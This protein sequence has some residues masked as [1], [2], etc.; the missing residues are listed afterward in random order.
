LNP[1]K[2]VGTKSRTPRRATIFRPSLTK[3]LLNGI[4]KNSTVNAP[5]HPL[6]DPEESKFEF[7]DLA[8]IHRVVRYLAQEQRQLKRKSDHQHTKR[9]VKFHLA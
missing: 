3:T 6:F 7:E 9:L 2:F 5:L 8:K 4:H 1:K